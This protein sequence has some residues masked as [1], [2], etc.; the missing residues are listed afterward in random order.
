MNRDRTQ[1]NLKWVSCIG[2]TI[3]FRFSNILYMNK[4]IPFLSA[5]LSLSGDYTFWS[6]IITIAYMVTVICSVYY[7]RQIEKGDKKHFLWLWISLFLII[8]GLNKQLDIQILVGMV[9]KFTARYWDIPQYRFLLYS[10]VLL[11]LFISMIALSVF[12]L[13]KIRGIIK[14]SLLALSGVA[15]IMFFVIVRASFIRIHRVHGL[16]LLGIILIFIDLFL[17]L[18]KMKTENKE[19]PLSS[20]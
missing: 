20:E 5:W 12:I 3:V 11:T 19:D 18:K 13:I 10:L 15:T 4:I 7:V 6:W 2:L 1:Y 9:G 16:E 8:M 17:N 14:Q